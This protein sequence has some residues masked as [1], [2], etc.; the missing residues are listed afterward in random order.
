M[1]HTHIH[2]YTHTHRRLN[3]NWLRTKLRPE[4]GKMKGEGK[5]SRKRGTEGRKEV[6]MDQG[7]REEVRCTCNFVQRYVA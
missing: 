6:G 3:G 4:E 5:E 7:S 1:T 2:T